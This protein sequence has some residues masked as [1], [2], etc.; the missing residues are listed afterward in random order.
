[1]DSLSRDDRDKHLITRGNVD[2]LVS[3]AVFLSKHP[4]SR[5]SFVTSPR[6]G[7]VELSKDRT[8]REIYLVDIALVPDVLRAAEGCRETQM[9]HAIDHHPSSALEELKGVKVVEE[10][11]SAAGVLFHH[12]EGSPHLK[13]LVAIADQMEYCE[14][15]LLHDMLR[16]HGM[17]KM[18]EEAKVLD[19]SW[20]LDIEDDEFRLAAARNLADGSWPSQV[21]SIKRRY[22]QVVNERRW[23]KAVARVKAGLEI[24]GDV[25]I[26][27]CRDK[28]RSLYGFGTRALVDVAYRRGC[29]YAMM[30]H[31]RKDTC[32]VSLRGM[33]REGLDVG[34]F[35]EGFTAVHGMEGGGHPTAA[36]ARIPVMMEHRFMD[37]FVSASFT[38]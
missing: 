37:E 6:A 3:A 19:F 38:R 16:K 13:K 18:D 31:E 8:S 21:P 24:K 29:K 23:P 35:V 34:N 33:K 12:L 20:R 28:N 5:V 4:L 10:G 1:M 32:C 14:T 36:G 17:Q 27:A 30:L 25:A 7:A 15:Q 9:V 26:L 11:M 22:I 2:G